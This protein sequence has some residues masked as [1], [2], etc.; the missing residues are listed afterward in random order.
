MNVQSEVKALSVVLD[1][2]P[3]QAVRE[4]WTLEDIL[5]PL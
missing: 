4:G 5:L 3:E 1:R 2:M